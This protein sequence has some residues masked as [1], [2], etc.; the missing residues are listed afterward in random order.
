MLAPVIQQ[1]SQRSKEV[2]KDR[3]LSISAV[4]FWVGF[5]VRLETLLGIEGHWVQ[6]K[7]YGE[8]RFG[9]FLRGASR[10]FSRKLWQNISGIFLAPTALYVCS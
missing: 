7:P 3:T 2:S 10:E 6:K 1:V 4:V 5:W 8:E 9:S